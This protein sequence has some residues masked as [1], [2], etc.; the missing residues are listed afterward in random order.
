MKKFLLGGLGLAAM[1][2]SASAADLAVRPVYKVLLPV[3]A[4]SFSWTGFYLG[5]ELGGKWG[6]TNW[7]TTSNS[8]FP[9]TILDASFRRNE[10]PSGFRAGG[11]AG[12]NWQMTDWVV[13]LEGS[14]AWA[15]NT[16]RAAGIP[17][18]AI[19]C[20]PGAPGP[21]VDVA[22]VK[23]GWDAS[24]RARLGYLVTA[25]LLFYGT[26]GVAWQAIQASGFCQ[27]SAGDPQC[28][29][30]V[31]SPFDTQTNSEVLTGWSVGG[32]VEAR[33]YGGWLLRGEYRY[34]NFGTFNGVLPFNSPP[35][36]LGTDY[37]R[38]NLS[39]NTQIATVG[40]AYKFDSGGAAVA[41]Y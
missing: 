23:M 1:A 12:Y 22:S 24:V 41:G 34:S 5:G 20:F 25:G 16:A 7:T 40:L 11:Y 2:A 36:P 10:D 13:G 26:G 37:V 8:D 31:G 33:I 32:G 21:G 3:I 30:A 4:P 15:N 27:H 19:L 9:G 28:T 18:C 38:Y 39:V 29:F 6:R 35:T 14:G 17:G